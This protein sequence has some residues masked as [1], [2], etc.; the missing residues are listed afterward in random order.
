MC[1]HGPS[2]MLGS[3]QLQLARRPVPAGLFRLGFRL[4]VQA[5]HWHGQG[6]TRKSPGML[7]SAP[8]YRKSPVKK[9]EEKV[10]PSSTRSCLAGSPSK[11]QLQRHLSA[12]RLRGVSWRCGA[13]EGAG[14]V[15]PVPWPGAHSS[16][17]DT[18]QAGPGRGPAV[19]CCARLPGRKRH[20][21]T[22]WAVNSI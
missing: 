2:A 8:A 14:R 18:A 13:C 16:R 21:T 22:P 15:T 9:T 12:L 7:L 17:R 1:I 11:R 20:A 19:L 4:A 6:N 3:R 5:V 10:R